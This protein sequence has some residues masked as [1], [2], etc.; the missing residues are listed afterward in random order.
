[1][2]PLSKRARL[3]AAF[4]GEAVDRVPVALW[5]HWPGDD[6]RAEDLAAAQLAFQ[7]RYDWDFIKVTPSSAFCVEDWGVRTAYEGTTEGTRTYLER[8]VREPE[9]WGSLERLD[10]QRGA[11]GR[12]IR[13][14]RQIASAVGDRVPFIQTVFNPLSVAR[15]L[16]G[17]DALLVHLRTHPEA[18]RQ[19]LATIAR[20]TCD[21]VA[22]VMRTGASGIFLAVQHAQYGLLSA[23]EYERFGRP[24]DL[25]VLEAAK[26]S[27]FNLLH[28]HGVD[29]MFDRLANYPVQ[30]INWH[31]RETPPTL[32]GGATR[33]PGALVGGLRQ[34]ETIVRGS[35]QDVRAEAQDALAQ[36]SGRRM[37]LG[38]GCVTPIVAPT[39]N[40]RAVR[41]AV[42][43]A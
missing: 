31:D 23:E 43:P 6:Q 27:W 36:T 32:A 2:T 5:R 39:S 35:P 10:P 25:Q 37:V 29:V 13:C 16:S 4:S 33:F 40:L 17:D 8:R 26:G 42:E 30:A 9:D 38:T 14:L 11:L 1:M 41:E 12:Q 7:D 15:Y 24:H 22:E 21:F 3:E 18:V 19:G 34:W 28:L 20:T